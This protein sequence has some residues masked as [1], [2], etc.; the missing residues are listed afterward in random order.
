MQGA[1]KNPKIPSPMGRGELKAL[2]LW[3]LTLPGFLVS[4]CIGIRHTPYATSCFFSP[5]HISSTPQHRLPHLLRGPK[6][7]GMSVGI[8]IQV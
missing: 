4:N 7:V 2:V 1:H 5:S 3:L 6:R 8:W